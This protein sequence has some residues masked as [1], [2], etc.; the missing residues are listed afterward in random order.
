[1]IKAM[2]RALSDGNGLSSYP[3]SNEDTAR[4]ANGNGGLLAE[5]SW[6]SLESAFKRMRDLVLGG[7]KYLTVIRF[8]L[9]RLYEIQYA[10]RQLGWFNFGGRLRLTVQL[11]RVTIG[12]P[13]ALDKAMREEQHSRE[14]ENDVEN[15]RVRAASSIVISDRKGLLGQRGRAVLD[16]V[17]GALEKGESW[18]PGSGAAQVGVMT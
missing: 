17:C 12:I 18:I 16:G 13:M 14:D 7:Q 11:A 5:E 9:I 2:L 15:S 1:M 6:D 8:E 4:S 10:L 3:H